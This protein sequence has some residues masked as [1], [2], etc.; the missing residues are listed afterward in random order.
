MKIFDR[1]KFGSVT[2]IL[3][4]GALFFC[5]ASEN[6]TGIPV[7]NQEIIP[8]DLILNIEIVG[9][10]QNIP[11]G[12]GSGHIKCSANATNA[13]KYGFKFN[14]GVEQMSTDGKIDFT[15]VEDGINTHSITVVAYS[16]TNNTINSIKT[17]EVFVYTGELKLIWS[18]EFNTNG[19][20]DTTRWAYD[21]GNGCPN[22]CGWGN[23]ESQYYTDRKENVIVIDGK[24]KITAKKEAFQGSQYTS[25]KIKTQDKF[26]FTYGRVEVRAKLPEG[27]G[28]WPAIWMLGANIDTVG[29]PTCGEVDIMEHFGHIP[30][31][32]SSA[33]HT[34]SC[35]GGCQNARVGETTVNDFSNEFHVYALE[36]DSEEIKFYLDNS[37]LYAYN[38]STKNE[39]NWPFNKDQFLIMNIAMGAN[40][41]SIDPNFVQSS[42]EVDYV[43]VFQ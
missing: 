25:T 39:N 29:W 36:W 27:G 31:K 22:I 12:D 1:L 35:N 19:A 14:N 5:G 26:E 38:P 43:R 33:T 10:N 32:I 23:G 16:E 13:V 9:A 11:N 15:F 2:L 21:E 37:F 42:M 18:D 17:A 3:L 41:F 20:P 8:S 4:L 30:T 6:S 28:T 34:P 24:L 7:M 40:W